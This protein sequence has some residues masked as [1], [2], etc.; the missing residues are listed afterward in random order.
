MLMGFIPK[1][2]LGGTLGGNHRVQSI[3]PGCETKSRLCAAPTTMTTT[4]TTTA[5][6]TATFMASIASPF[7]AP[8]IAPIAT[9]PEVQSKPPVGFMDLPTEI[10]LAIY[11]EVYR[12]VRAESP[13][14]PVELSRWYPSPKACPYYVRPVLLPVESANDSDSTAN[15]DEGDKI[16]KEQRIRA[17]RKLLSPNRP[18]C[19]VPSALL[20]TCRQVYM[21]ARMLPFAQSEFTFVNWFSSGVKT[22]DGAMDRLVDWQKA[23]MRWVRIEVMARDLG[24]VADKP[25]GSDWAKVCQKWQDGLRGLRLKIVATWPPM[26]AEKGRLTSSV[27]E[28]FNDESKNGQERCLPT[29]CEGWQWAEEQGLARLQALERI[30]VELEIAE[31]SAARKVAWCQKLEKVLIAAGKTGVEVACVEQVG[32]V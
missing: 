6:I 31:W 25:G 15:E 18:V 29:L 9:T 13:F 19:Y 1:Q 32:R 28:E 23:S 7:T 21:E 10:R 14:R 26:V 8:I 5:T 3:S 16:I 2:I 4:M 30:E 17:W 22:A 24:A 11:D 20:Q 12:D 27:A